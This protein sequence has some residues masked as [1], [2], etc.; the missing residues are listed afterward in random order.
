MR[1]WC[2]SAYEGA[3]KLIE[4]NIKQL[5]ETIETEIEEGAIGD[6]A[7]IEVAEMDEKDYA[8]LPE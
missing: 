5:L 1:V 6:I 4:P 3:N 8:T 2:Y 7:T